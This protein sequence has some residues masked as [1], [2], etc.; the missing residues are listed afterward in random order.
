MRIVSLLIPILAFLSSCETTDSGAYFKL[1]NDTTFHFIDEVAPTKDLSLRKVELE[2]YPLMPSACCWLDSLMVVANS[3]DVETGIFAVYSGERLVAK[4]G[5]I[6]S[7]PDDYHR[8]LLVTKG[9]A[10]D[11]I[12]V[13]GGNFIERVKVDPANGDVTRY[14]R[15]K[16]PSEMNL[17]YQVICDNDTLLATKG[18]SDEQIQ[19]YDK[20]S[21][22]VSG[23]TLYDKPKELEDIDGLCCNVQLYNAHMSSNGR[24]LVAAYWYLKMIDIYDWQTGKTLHLAFKDYNCNRIN[25]TERKG[26]IKMERGKKMFF[27][28]AYACDDCFYAVCWDAPADDVKDNAVMSKML[29]F[30]YQGNLLCVYKFDQA[31]GHVAVK[32]NEVYALAIDKDDDDEILVYNCAL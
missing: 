29:K 17:C 6:G 32:G 28:F 21:H 11:E 8:P 31:V 5:Q 25:T 18:F 23:L 19:L 15:E 30:D 7:G 20:R 3:K 24:Y 9:E 16:M 1:E 2:D 14:G 10:E 12:K 26:N 4:F 22:K 27:T 13:C